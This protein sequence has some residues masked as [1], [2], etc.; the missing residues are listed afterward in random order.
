[1]KKLVTGLLL[2]MCAVAY[3]TDIVLPF[4]AG[5]STSTVM[6]VLVPELESAGIQTQ[7]K[8]LGNCQTARAQIGSRPLVY[9]WSNDLDCAVPGRVTE[10]NFVGLVNWMPLYLCGKRPV[11]SDYASGTPRVAV[12]I[13][14]FYTQLARSIGQKVN[15]NTR[16]INYANTGAVKTALQ[17]NEV[18]LS[19]TTNG[20]AMAAEGLVTCYA[21][22]TVTAMPGL[23]TVQS[24]I[25]NA[26]GSVFSL[27]IWMTANGMSA[28]DVAK[29][30][31]SV[32]KVMQGPVYREMT[33]KK[34]RREL[35]DATVEQQIQR[36]NQSL[37]N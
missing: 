33:T 16:V 15:L 7:A 14:E 18:D 6:Q 2:S 37:I 17:T 8:F 19:L 31:A 36:V 9:V 24:I 32:Q 12:N 35:P 27:S 11:L 29:Y 1:M 28:A 5:G 23:V 3:A 4:S 34:L 25:G 30:R 21:A 22:T 13:G 20:P 26:P 10:Q